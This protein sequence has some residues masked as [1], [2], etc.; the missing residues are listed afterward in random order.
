MKENWLEN[1]ESNLPNF[2]SKLNKQEHTYQAVVEG[3]TNEGKNLNLG[4][5]C[6]ALKIFY[7]T[8][9]WDKLDKEKQKNG[10]T[11]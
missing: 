1:L 8:N 2:L 5:S 10:L 6:Y 9:L 4:L 7:I 3:N 11:T